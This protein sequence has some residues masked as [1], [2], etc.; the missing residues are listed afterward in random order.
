MRARRRRRS[1]DGTVTLTVDATLW[2]DQV[3]FSLAPT[4]DEETELA[5]DEPPRNALARGVK[6]ALGYRFAFEPR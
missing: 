1:A 2:F 5:I 6:K 4:S 3:D